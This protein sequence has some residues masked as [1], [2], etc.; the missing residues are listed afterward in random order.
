MKI[1]MLGPP[2]AGKG[3]Q[4]QF[5][6][7][8][9]GIP[10]IS[11]GDMLRSA[12][13]QG[14]E[15]GQKVQ[16]IMDRGELVDDETIIAL[17]KQRIQADDCHNGF[18][19]DGFPR[20]IPQAKACQEHGITLDYVIEIKV[21]DEVIIERL[22]GRR[23]HPA[24][25]R[26]YHVTHSPPKVSGVDDETGESLIQRD[27][28]QEEVVRHRLQVYREQTAPLVEFYRHLDTVGKTNYI[29]VNGDQDL[30]QVKQAILASLP[31][32]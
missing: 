16:G 5:V 10:Q 9:L 6:C 7:D 1:L 12:I 14:N 3:T 13:Q 17:V 23:I 15:L 19:L 20:T 11:T 26:T 21:P 25:G 28:D 29:Q 24:S 22:C 30:E 31:N 4:A 8:H 18:L 32:Q 2:G 27:D